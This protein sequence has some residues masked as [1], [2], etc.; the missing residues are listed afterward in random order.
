MIHLSD[1]CYGLHACP[2]SRL[3]R[4]AT[5]C[6]YPYC[7]L[8]VVVQDLGSRSDM[9][10]YALYSMYQP[11]LAVQRTVSTVGGI[12]LPSVSLSPFR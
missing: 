11:V 12:P 1:S 3:W 4:V 10:D 7:C 8:S 9:P 6:M 2:F 5:Y